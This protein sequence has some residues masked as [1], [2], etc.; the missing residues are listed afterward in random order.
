[1]E[2]HRRFLIAAIISPWILC[3][4]HS[5]RLI[6]RAHFPSR[7]I[8]ALIGKWQEKWTQQTDEADPPTGGPRDCRKRWHS[9]GDI[10]GTTHYFTYDMIPSHIP[11][12]HWRTLRTKKFHVLFEFFKR[13]NI[14]NSTNNCILRPQ[15]SMVYW[16]LLVSGRVL[17]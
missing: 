16:I 17:F 11:A 15:Q 5:C 13:E 8:S 7:E 1:M 9:W 14:S 4:I 6:L 10:L 2:D 12:Q 3:S